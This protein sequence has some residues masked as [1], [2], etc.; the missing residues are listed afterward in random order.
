[1]STTRIPV[2]GSFIGG[3]SP[4]A[5][6]SLTHDSSTERRVRLSHVVWTPVELESARIEPSWADLDAANRCIVVD[7]RGASRDR[8]TAPTSAV[9][10]TGVAP[11]LAHWLASQP[12]PV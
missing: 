12:I 9:A 10:P 4:L 8:E 1:M 7:L 11:A 6:G 5:N 3:S 2:S